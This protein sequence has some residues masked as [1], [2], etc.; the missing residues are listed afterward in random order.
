[1]SEL[2]KPL[3]WT[4]AR[5]SITPE[6]RY[7]R[8]ARALSWIGVVLLLTCQMG[9]QQTAT[10]SQVKAAY[11]YNFAKISQWPAQ[12]LPDGNSPLVIGV[13]GGS[14]EFVNVLRATLAGRTVGSHAIEI[15]H[16]RSPEELKFCHLVFFRASE[17]NTPGAIAAVSKASVLLVGEDKNFLSQGGM[18]NL[19]M[20]NGRV[21]FEVDPESLERAN[22]HYGASFLAQAAN[23]SALPSAGNSRSVKIRVPPDYPEVA[24][25]LNLKG[26]VQL[27]ALVR[28]DGTVKEIRVVG[29]HPLLAE[30]AL[31]AVKQWRYEAGSKET[32]EVVR[33]NFGE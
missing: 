3:C 21:S 22:I 20:T 17:R 31:Q 6:Y 10:E 14:E 15:R 18:I 26:T 9:A 11:L 30:A 8:P 1:M 27:Q 33:I 19:T 23:A 16:L 24:R 13:L 29:G 12:V 32:T 2:H 25:Q 7:H 5:P 4:G 28:A